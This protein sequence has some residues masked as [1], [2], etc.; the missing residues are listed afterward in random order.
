MASKSIRRDDALTRAGAHWRWRRRICIVLVALSGAPWAGG[1]AAQDTT[2]DDGPTLANRLLAGVVRIHAD[3]HGFGV[4]VGADPTFVYIATA[5]HVVGVGVP[6][7][8]HGCLGALPAA[9]AAERIGGA[10]PA[11]EDLALLRVP[12]PDGYRAIVRAL[13]PAG[14]VAVTDPAWLLGRDDVC[15]VLPR[16]GAVAAAPTARPA[17]RV[18]MSE[19]L[20][21]SSGA[22]VATGRGIIGIATDSDNANITVLDIEH[23]ARRVRAVGGSFDLVDA[24]NEPPNDPQAA[25]LALAEMLSGLLRE[26]RDAQTVLRQQTVK[27]EYYV[28]TVTEYGQVAERFL[29]SKDKYTGTLVRHWHPE[30]APQ[31]LALRDRLQAVHDNFLAVNSH[32]RQIVETERVPKAVRIRME[33]LDPELESLQGAIA[34]F[35]RLLSQRRLVN[36]NPSS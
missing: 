16:A 30:V 32:A 34:Q 13:A 22:P 27:R 31:W 25:E 15:G 14:R 9:L 4:V 7:A 18:D 36:A 5:Q 28:R 10:D 20:G 29:A 26:M 6:V 1:A 35:L 3:E 12:R 21:G 24:H 33:A 2:F 8:V 11:G 19:V 17:W 23:I